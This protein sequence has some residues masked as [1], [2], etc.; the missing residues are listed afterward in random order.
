MVPL[1]LEGKPRNYERHAHADTAPETTIHG[2]T[3]RASVA[4]ANRAQGLDIVPKLRTIGCI[5]QEAPGVEAGPIALSE[6]EIERL[7]I[8]EHRRWTA[9]RL[10]DGWTPGDGDAPRCETRDLVPWDELTREEQEWD[11]EAVRAIPEVLARVGL[12]IGRSEE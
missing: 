1:A 9:E 2:V 10:A 7:A 12:E 4:S 6:T 11:R 8:L 3:S 5:A